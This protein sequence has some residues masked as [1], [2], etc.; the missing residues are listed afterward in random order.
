MRYRLPLLAESVEI[1]EVRSLPELEV[2][3]LSLL[4]LDD[5]L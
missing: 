5:E 4:P 3:F 1:Y 2:K